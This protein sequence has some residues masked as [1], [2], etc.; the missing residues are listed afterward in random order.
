[1]STAE[2]HRAALS[3]PFDAERIFAD[4]LPY[5]FAFEMENKW[6]KEFD[7]VISAAKIEE[8]TRR[9]GGR[10]FVSRNSIGRA[11]SASRPVSSGSSGGGS[12]SSGSRGGGSS[13]GGRGGGGGR[14]R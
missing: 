1:M 2:E 12:R 11:I 5:A 14:G 8:Y 9:A 13:G 6:I 10:D 3:N 7:G 4:Y